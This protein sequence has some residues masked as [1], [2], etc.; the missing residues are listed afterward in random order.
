MQIFV[1]TWTGYTL[2]LEVVP[3][4]T[5]HS[6]KA[7]IHERS[8]ISPR[9]RLVLANTCTEMEDDKTLEDYRIQDGTVLQVQRRRMQ[10]F[11]VAPTDK[12]V[13]LEVSP[14]DTIG[15]VKRML[16]DRTGIPLHLYYLNLTGARLSDDLTLEHYIIG[17]ET[18]LRCLVPLLSCV[19]CPRR[20]T[21]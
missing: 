11:V 7:K 21:N 13:P 3:R 5:I 9:E 10:I 1:R 20:D 2:A 12:T 4:D 18:T 8:Y 14:S 17:K 19:K 15:D 16:Q 6:V